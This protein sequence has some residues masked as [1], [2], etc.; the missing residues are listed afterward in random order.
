[1]ATP[2]PAD[3][4]PL[5][6][7]VLLILLALAARPLHGYG[8][9]R[10]VE[11]RSGGDVLLQTGALY[12]ELRRLLN[13]G[14]IMECERPA[15]EAS[16]DERRRYYTLTSFGQRVM[17]AEVERMSRLVRAARLTANGKRPRLI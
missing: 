12:R 5:K 2:D 4:L 11:D 8:I 15:D 13:D 9:I 7:N 3:L 17:D 14:L 6:S 1:M 16:D 10:E